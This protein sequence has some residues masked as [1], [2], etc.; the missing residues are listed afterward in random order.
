VHH[1][2]QQR[3]QAA[4]KADGGFTLIELLIV[5]VILGVL[6]G[7]VVFSVQAV[8]DRG[9]KNACLTNLKSIETASAAYYADKGNYPADV[10][11]LVTAN[12]LKEEPP[13]TYT[14]TI[15]GTTGNVTS[16]PGC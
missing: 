15:N 9:S 5:I 3:L 4:R 1:R 13:A 11:A 14:Y 7:I 10:P 12:Y 8:V 6:A 2:L 16:T